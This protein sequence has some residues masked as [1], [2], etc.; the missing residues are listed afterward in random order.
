[1]HADVLV[2]LNRSGFDLMLRCRV[3]CL[4]TDSQV[5]P[6][7]RLCHVLIKAQQTAFQF[8]ALG[9]RQRQFSVADAVPKFTDQ[10]KALRRM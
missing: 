7:D 1:M 6:T 10:G 5:F 8:P 2:R 3:I 9:W 4:R